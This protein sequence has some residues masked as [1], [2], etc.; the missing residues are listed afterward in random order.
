MTNPQKIITAVSLSSAEG[1]SIFQLV[2]LMVRPAT[3]KLWFSLTA[4][5]ADSCFQKKGSLDKT[6]RYL[7][8]YTRQ[9]DAVSD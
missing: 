1:F 3:L 9:T 7:P 4:V 8:S 5:T 2:V 6:V